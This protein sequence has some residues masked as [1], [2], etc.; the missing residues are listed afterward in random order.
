MGR[1]RKEKWIAEA[2][3]KVKPGSII[4]RFPEF[5]D[6][7]NDYRNRNWW[8]KWERRR[9]WFGWLEDIMF[10]IKLRKLSR[11]RKRKNK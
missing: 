9:Y 6:W 4:D 3:R 11:K 10:N 2:K 8:K 7:D 5:V 1:S